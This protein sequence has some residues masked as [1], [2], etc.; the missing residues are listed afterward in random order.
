MRT[1]H[2]SRRWL[3]AGVCLLATWSA[4][5]RGANTLSAEAR[6]ALQRGL[7]AAQRHE[8]DAAIKHFR[9]AYG[10]APFDAPRPLINLGL[11]T[12]RAGNREAVA[13]AWFRA[14]LAAAPGALN[15]DKVRDNIRQ[16]EKKLNADI[17]KLITETRRIAARIKEG[18]EDIV[19]SLIFMQLDAGRLSM[20]EKEIYS[21]K[22]L[23]YEARAFARLAQKQVAVGNKLH[24]RYL[25][26]AS[27]DAFA[28]MSGLDKMAQDYAFARAELSHA[29]LLMGDIEGAL[30][31]AKAAVSVDRH[32]HID[33]FK[34]IAVTQ[35]GN[36]RT[37]LNTLVI[38]DSLKEGNVAS[39]ERNSAYRDVL[40]AVADRGEVAGVQEVAGKLP[41]WHSRYG[42]EALAR[43]KAVSGD[44]A[45]A[46]KEA[47]R[48]PVR[49]DAKAHVA[50]G[51][52]LRGDL[53]KAYEIAGTIE[54]AALNTKAKKF[55]A[56]Y[57][58][59]HGDYDGA[60]KLTGN[61]WTTVDRIEVYRHIVDQIPEAGYKKQRSQCVISYWTNLAVEL[62]NAPRHDDVEMFIQSDPFVLPESVMKNLKE[63]LPDMYK[64]VQDQAQT[65]EH[66]ARAA[67][68]RIEELARQL[69]KELNAVTEPVSV[70]SVTE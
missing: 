34:R 26:K 25:I 41:Q 59:V 39:Q 49:E 10:L 57:R 48:F 62:E 44:V 20:A 51:L 66:K 22:V 53:A 50:E 63:R 36:W 21:L 65:N 30:A 9:T 45:G 31:S 12:Q 3:L 60:L 67:I 1:W 15:V 6:D 54:T 28:R 18:H 14:Y 52:A 56:R 23:L 16:L 35:S 68:A 32:V 43:A 27:Q 4:V 55:I 58:A 64:Q 17:D 29:Q 42:Y 33:A 19:L 46:Q 11:A 47:A 13:I 38:M 61:L 2:Y 5:A 8:W 7:T 70:M 69:V 24:A 40:L 37:A